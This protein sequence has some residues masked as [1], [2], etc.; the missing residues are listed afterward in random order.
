M[1]TMR[2]SKSSRAG[3]PSCVGPCRTLCRRELGARDFSAEPDSV[4]TK[5]LLGRYVGRR[6]SSRC[7]H[8]G[9]M[10]EFHPVTKHIGAEVTGVDLRKPLAQE[11]VHILRPGWLK[12]LVLFF[13]DQRIDDEQ[14]LQFALNFGTLNHPA[15]KRD[16]ASPDPRAR[17]DRAQGRGRGRVAQR[18]H[19]RVAPADGLSCCAASSSPAWAATPAGPTPTWPTR[20][21]RPPSSACATSSTAVHDIT[22]SM[23][24][25]IAKGHPFDLAEVQ[26]ECRRSSARWSACT[27]RPG[28]RRCS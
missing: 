23:K 20:R 28:A 13:R 4:L 10:I 9:V 18:Q 22:A 7:P 14:H 6:G 25:A 16:A 12:H 11:E 17:P 19:L 26:A 8:G 1:S 27:P 3:V 21:S 15:F 24:K 2:S 5:Q